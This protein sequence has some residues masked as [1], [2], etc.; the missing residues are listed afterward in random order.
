[1]AIARS[2]PRIPCITFLLPPSRRNV[3]ALGRMGAELVGEVEYDG[4]VFRK[5]RL[6]TSQ[7]I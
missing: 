7:G 5:Y 2:D 6:D 1:L 3:G 4:A